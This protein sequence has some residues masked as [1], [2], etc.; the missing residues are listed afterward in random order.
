MTKFPQPDNCHLAQLNIAHAKFDLNSPQM[1]DFTN[2]IEAVNRVAEHSPGFVW[3]LTDDASDMSV[4]QDQND[5]RLLLNM[6]V[7]E[8]ALALQHYLANTIHKKIFSR[9]GEWFV[10]S[11][12]PHLVMWWLPKGDMPLLADGLSR[13]A[14]LEKN[15]PTEQGFSWTNL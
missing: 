4:I 14:A 6:S 8:S 3:R 10:R 7:W 2:A 1:S 15:G 9:G 12:A 11:P 13:L 5:P